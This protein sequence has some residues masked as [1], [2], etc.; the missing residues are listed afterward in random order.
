MH[1]TD[2]S[3][4]EHILAKTNTPALAIVQAAQRAVAQALEADYRPDP[5]L[6]PEISRVVSVATS[7]A[8]RHGPLI[9]RVIGNALERG[10]L[11]VLRN[12]SIPIT[13]GALALTDSPDYSQFVGRQ[14]A[15]DEN[16]VI[17]SVDADVIPIDEANRWAGAFSI[18]RGGGATESRKRREGARQLRAANFILASWLRKQG[19]REIETAVV[20]VIDF[21]G[22]SGFVKDLTIDRSG[23]DSFF[24]LPIVE[25]VDQMTAAMYAAIDVQMGSLLAP[26]I[27]AMPPIATP[28]ATVL[29]EMFTAPVTQTLLRPRLNV[30]GGAAKNADG[31]AGP[32]GRGR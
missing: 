2:Y 9:E 15:F 5:I 31:D 6:R 8:K 32:R 26:V 25:D 11:T 23:L 1:P 16:D 10:G 21:F 3:R 20:G 13:R 28:K 14:I 29:T 22:Q 12:R 24:G 17:D 30:A 18:K 19:Y 4:S 27:A 7:A